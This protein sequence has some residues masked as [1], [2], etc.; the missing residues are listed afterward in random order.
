MKKEIITSDT[1]VNFGEDEVAYQELVEKITVS[2][3][4]GRAQALRSI[5][6]SIIET[7]WQNGE[8]IIEYEQGGK[9]RAK[10]GTGLID[11]LSHDLTIRLGRGFSRSNLRNMRSFYLRFPIQQ[12]VAGKL[13]W[14]HYC[15]LIKFDDD[16]ERDFYFQQCIL[17]NWSIEDFRRQKKSGLFLRL[18][19]SK[20]KE[21]I[22][23]LSKK[24]KYYRKTK[25]RSKRALCL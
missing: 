2:Q 17:E 14:S 3:R 7:N 16:L 22:L 15:E 23:N 4:Q 6:D 1:N 18:A 12:K 21:E 11:R 25:R 8:Y 13:S 20:N 5:N 10:Y 19:M 24:R 9:A